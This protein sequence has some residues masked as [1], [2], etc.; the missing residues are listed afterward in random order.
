[1]GRRAP[2]AMDT[3]RPY[4]LTAGSTPPQETSEGEEVF[5]ATDTQKYVLQVSERQTARTPR[6]GHRVGVKTPNPKV[7][8]GREHKNPKSKCGWKIPKF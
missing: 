8:S 7:K 3:P 1:M 5:A 6:T 2:L 4:G